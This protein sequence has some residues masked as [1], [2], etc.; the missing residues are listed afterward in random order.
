MARQP[1]AVVH[2]PSFTYRNLIVWKQGIELVE[3]CYKLTALFPK[4]E[5]FGL[6]SQIRRASVSIP[7]NVAEGHC[8]RDTANW[9]RI[10]KWR[11]ASVF[12]RRTTK[13]VS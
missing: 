5:L 9:K 11:F 7:A 2:M 6:T 10:S 12:C 3:E 1:H 8:R 13:R 4:S